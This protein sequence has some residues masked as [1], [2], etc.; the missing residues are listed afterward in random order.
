[1][2]KH[3]HT[4]K[5]CGKGYNACDT[6]LNE[7][8]YAPWRA[9]ACSQ[10]HFQAYMVLWEYGNGTLKREVARD[11]LPGM[12]IDG[13]ENYPEHNRVVIAE[14]LK[15]EEKPIIEVVESLVAEPLVVANV[16]PLKVE[17]PVVLELPKQ[18]VPAQPQGYKQPQKPYN[19]F[20]KYKK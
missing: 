15:E 14:I 10:G 11:V 13:W 8:N 6:C 19:N 2:A 4:C 5:V 16:E 9:I 1:M 12:D 17:E 7:R 3:N 18:V 20:Q